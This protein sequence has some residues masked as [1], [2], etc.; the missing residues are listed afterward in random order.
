M[1]DTPKPITLGHHSFPFL[2]DNEFLYGDKTNVI[3]EL[4]TGVDR[5]IFMIRPRRFGKSLLLST[6]KEIFQGGPDRFSG[7][8]ISGTGYGFPKSHV[9]SFS[10]SKFG[11]DPKTLDKNITDW[12]NDLSENYGI[13]RKARNCADG[14]SYLIEKLY[15]SKRSIPLYFS[16]DDF[17]PTVVESRHISEITVPPKDQL[18][19]VF[20]DYRQ[21]VVLIDEYDFALI[22]NLGNT[23]KISAIQNILNE[24]FS[25]IKDTDT[26]KRFLL[27]TGITKF[28]E[29][30]IGSGM[31]NL[32]DITYDHKYSDICGLTESDIL[33]NL[34]V[35]LESV[36]NYSNAY[37]KSVKKMTYKHVFKSIINM[38]DGY[39]WDGIKKIINPYSALNYLKTKKLGPYW[40]STGGPNLL[41]KLKLVDDDYFKMFD[42]N[43]ILR[44]IQPL[45]ELH[46]LSPQT[47]LLNTG[48]LTIDRIEHPFESIHA[49]EQD[50]EIN[51]A[52]LSDGEAELSD[53]EAEKI[54]DNISKSTYH[55]HIPNREVRV[56]Y[57]QEYLI[58]SIYKKLSDTERSDLFDKFQLFVDFFTERN[59]EK[60][61]NAL[62]LIFSS[63]PR[64][65]HISKES[66]YKTIMVSALSLVN[67][68]V[69]AERNTYGGIIDIFVELN[70]NTV[71]IVEVKFKSIYEEDE[72]DSIATPDLKTK[73]I[74]NAFG[75][76][77]RGA[78]EQ[79]GAVNP[80]V[81]ETEDKAETKKGRKLDDQQAMALLDQGITKAFQQI[82]DRG[83]ADEFKVPG[84]TVWFAAV[85]IVGKKFLKI[86]FKPA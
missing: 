44:E 1:G 58:D 48:Y 65:I 18:V 36:A 84:K 56:Q 83:Y 47:A 73:I 55:L 43:I 4:L 51:N 75:E 77:P 24:F 52:E 33:E 39:S 31:N 62:K 29:L 25:A 59:V 30:S 57:S 38:Y 26:M 35:Y 10:F 12:I 68:R 9:I 20:P 67:G 54:L 37:F 17:D 7:L 72:N 79:V 78:P 32:F 80:P 27:V 5:D 82:E 81:T 19:P 23:K 6:I 66:Y 41:K 86:G 53:A 21:V 3:H 14:I 50:L 34:Q 8:K 63:Y 60:S 2:I 46:T 76:A 69:T 40:Y 71:I 49:I 61:E 16:R 74:S 42:R 15:A 64:Q 13:N 28:R 45:Q 70:T 11:A 22:S 85:S